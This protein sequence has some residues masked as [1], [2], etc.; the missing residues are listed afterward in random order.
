METRNKKQKKW[1]H[2]AVTY[3]VYVPSFCDANGDGIGDLRG[4]TSKLEYLEQLGIDC[5]WLTPIMKSPFADCGY[6]VSD[7]CSINPVFGTME[8]FD[9]LLRKT[10]DRA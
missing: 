1:W 2:D 6:D 8:D 7:Y 10:H 5:I 3:E 9:E 4:V